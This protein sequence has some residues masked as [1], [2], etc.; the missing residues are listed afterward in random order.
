M[1]LSDTV[2]IIPPND[3]EAVLIMRIADKM[4]INIIRSGQAHGATLDKGRDFVATVRKGGWKKV[5]VV[6]MPGVK[7]EEKI[8]KFGIELVIIDHHYYDDLDRA[9]NK[10]TG[11]VLPSSLEQFLK[12]FRLGSVR[13]KKLGF[14]PRLVRGIAIMDRGF[15]WALRRAHYSKKEI[16]KIIDYQKQLMGSVKDMSH[17]KKKDKIAEDLWKIRK[18]WGKFIVIEDNSGIGMRSRISLI[19]A[20]EIG[21]PTS[22]IIVE[23]KRG[24]IYVQESKHARALLK[25]FGGFTFGMDCNWGYQN[26]KKKKK[27]TLEKVQGFLETVIK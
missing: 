11:K 22:L 14:N 5:I 13:L 3:A 8:K 18:Q 25:H 10:K 23:K 2:L 26:S 7:N 4:G 9:H 21:K 24:F 27:V 20:R 1:K 15:V 6:E 17:E 19:I 16:E 12:L